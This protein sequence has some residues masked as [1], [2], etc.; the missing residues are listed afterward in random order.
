MSECRAERRFGRL[1]LTEWETTYQ[2]QRRSSHLPMIERH[3]TAHQRDPIIGEPANP[4]IGLGEIG[5]DRSTMRR[6]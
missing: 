2:P 5:Q 6:L 4:D 1:Y 3:E